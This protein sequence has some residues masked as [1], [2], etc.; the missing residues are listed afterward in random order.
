VMVLDPSSQFFSTMRTGAP[1]G[2]T[3]AAKK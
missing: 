2:A 3:P 1:S